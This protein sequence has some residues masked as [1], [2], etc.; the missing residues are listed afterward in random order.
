MRENFHASPLATR[1]SESLATGNVTLVV[2]DAHEPM[3]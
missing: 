2:T 3:P 1:H